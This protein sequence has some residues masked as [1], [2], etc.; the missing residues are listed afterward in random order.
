MTILQ[1]RLLA[2]H[3]KIKGAYPR[4]RCGD[5]RSGTVVLFVVSASTAIAPDKNNKR[6]DQP[7]HDKHPVLAVE[8]QNGKMPNKKL[9]RS[10]SP[11]F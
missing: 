5:R 11:N 9:Q 2:P 3:N 8:A 6:G 4:R 1:A 7:N 10:C